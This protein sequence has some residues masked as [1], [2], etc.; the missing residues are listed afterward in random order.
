VPAGVPQFAVRFWGSGDLERV[1]ATVFD[2]SGTQVWKQDDISTSQSY[3]AQR[4]DTQ[5]D[6]VW[7]LVL[8]RP[9]IGVLEDHYVELRGIPTVLG[10]RPDGLLA[11]A[12]R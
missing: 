9:K 12:T 10:F 8:S 2:A 4:Q 5:R 6:E 1:S 3:Q 11:P 7:R